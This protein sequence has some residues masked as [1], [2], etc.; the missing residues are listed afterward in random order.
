MRVISL[1]LRIYDV[2]RA[3]PLSGKAPKKQQK[4]S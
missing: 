4:N 1:P 3:L 2:N